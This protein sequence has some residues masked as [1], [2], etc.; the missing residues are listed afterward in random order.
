VHQATPLHSTDYLDEL[1]SLALGSRL[2]RLSERLIQQTANIYKAYGLKFEPRWFPVFSYL[3]HHGPTSVTG[4]ATAT[5]VTHPAVNQIAAELSENGLIRSEAD[6]RDARRR[7]LILTEKAHQT[8]QKLEPVWKSLHAALSSVNADVEIDLVN[9]V[10]AFE[11]AM[12][13]EGLLGRM[14]R[15]DSTLRQNGT[16]VIDFKSDLASDFARL[17]RAWIEKHFRLERED[18]RILYNPEQIIAQ[19]GFIFFVVVGDEVV[20]TCALLKSSD[21]EFEVAKMAVDEA[22]RGLGIGKLLLMR[23]IERAKES[24]AESLVLETNTNLT[25]AVGLYQSLGFV[26]C[27]SQHDSKYS[28]VDLVMRLPLSRGNDDQH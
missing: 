28:R 11:R 21:T 8:T 13:R 4:L 27:A 18:L 12:E 14:Q 20:G 3:L 22:Y 6:S 17:N 24:E 15:L 9:S 19:G 16:Q 25:A 7:I 23:C 2:K 5:G 26:K 1:G 10:L